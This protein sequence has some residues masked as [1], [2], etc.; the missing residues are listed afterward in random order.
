MLNA[1]PVRPVIFAVVSAVALAVGACGA[2]SSSGGSGSV[3]LGLVTSLSAPGD[4]RD[5]GLIKNVAD[6]WVKNANSNGGIGGRTVTLAV[7]DD[8]G[9]PDS[10]ASAATRVITQQHAVALLGMWNSSVVI[11]Q[12]N[13][14]KRYNIPMGVFYSWA[15]TITGTNLPQVYRIGPYNSLIAAD[16][17]PYILNKGYKKVA[18]VAE[19]TDYGSG[20]AN[21]FK[22]TLKAQPGGGS[23]SVEVQQF[24]AESQDLSTVLSKFASES[25]QPNVLIVASSYAADDLSI[26]QARQVGLKSDILAGWDYPTES[27]FWTTVGKAG[28]GVTYPTFYDKSISLT[29]EG[30]NFRDLYTKAYGTAPVIF[31][32]FEWDTFNVVKAAILKTG[33]TDPAKLVAALPS[34]QIQG[35][36][37]PNLTFSHQAG[38][39]HFNQWENLT[40]FFKQ[41][42]A[43]GQGDGDAQ[44]VF[45][46][47]PSS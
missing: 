33:S 45:T 36:T 34:L 31:Q 13:I 29:Q 11:A 42:T 28:V 2:G 47:K 8:G 4:Y 35:T 26:K 39:T 41:F 44:L 46:S 27:D 24:P 43:S 1:L 40:M 15:D 10:G 21:A 17:V 37:D 38:T 22:S 20:F 14:A 12:M 18:I 16:M 19:D 3:T 30:Q 9:A 23:V 7:A 6:L 5:G 32:Y 25:P